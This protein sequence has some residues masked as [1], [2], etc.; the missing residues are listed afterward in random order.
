[1]ATDRFAMTACVL[2]R[3]GDAWLLGLRA[4]GVSYA[5][6]TL[7][8][9]GGHVESD[10]AEASVLEA[11][12]R[13]EVLEESGIDLADVPLHYLE[14]ELFTTERGEPQVTVTFV[15]DAP[16]GAEPTAT[17]PEEVTSVGWWTTPEVEDDPR[18]PAWLPAL[19]TRAAAA[20]PH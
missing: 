17:A 14:S 1:V 8:L 4:A 5:P 9:I 18:S 6:G 13:R 11:T 16:P 10:D 12:G 19:L 20:F 7:G 3:R 15:A 2:L